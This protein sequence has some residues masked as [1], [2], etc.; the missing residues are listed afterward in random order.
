LSGGIAVTDAHQEQKRRSI[1]AETDA[2]RTAGLMGIDPDVIVKRVEGGK[3]DI[4]AIVE[5]FKK[6]TT[7]LP[8]ENNDKSGEVSADKVEGDQAIRKRRR[9]NIGDWADDSNDSSSSS[10]RESSETKKRI[11]DALGSI[12]A[13]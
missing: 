13:F 8:G 2:Y 7:A 10:Q 5:S 1:E 12:G 11:E 9:L 6:E 3:E 4:V